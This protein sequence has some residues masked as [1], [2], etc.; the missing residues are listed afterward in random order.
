MPPYRLFPKFTRPPP[1]DSAGTAELRYGDLD[2]T[3][4]ASRASAA[5]LGGAGAQNNDASGPRRTA[6]SGAEPAV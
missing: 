3:E 1:M 2:G 6:G 4:Q 5:A